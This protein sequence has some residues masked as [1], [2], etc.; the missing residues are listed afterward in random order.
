MTPYRVVWRETAEAELADLYNFI[1]EQRGLTQTAYDYAT[2][3]VARCEELASLPHAGRL[4]DDILPGIR[5]IAFESVVI[6]YQVEANLVT[7][8]N[9]MHRARDYQRLLGK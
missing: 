7:I 6:L 3:I 2:R 4:R 8:T 1:V 9:I 5:S